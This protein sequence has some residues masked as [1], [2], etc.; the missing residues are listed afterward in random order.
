MARKLRL[1]Y[2]GG[3]YHVLNCGVGTRGSLVLWSFG[4]SFWHGSGTALAR[5]W[6]GQNLDKQALGTVARPFTPPPEERN[7]APIFYLFGIRRVPH[8]SA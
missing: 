5:P 7:T 2:P 8:N 1:Q 6:H 4:L 3:I